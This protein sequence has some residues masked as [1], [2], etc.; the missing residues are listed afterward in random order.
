MIK[1]EL[2][3]AEDH[4]F[5]A[6]FRDGAT[7]EAQV[8]ADEVACP[9]CGSTDVS[10]ALMAPRIAKGRQSP[11]ER[12]QAQ[13]AVVAMLR[14]MRQEIEAK[15]EYVGPDF[16]EEAR[17]IHYGEVET[18]AIYGE[19]SETDAEALRDEGIEFARIPWLPPTN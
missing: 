3:C 6:W 8:G 12:A 9:V 13:A 7:F 18:K 11:E 19:A 1:F 5:E 16:A 2:R 4:G 15:A 14:E 10:K 17:K